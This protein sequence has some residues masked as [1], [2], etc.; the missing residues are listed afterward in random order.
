MITRPMLA[1]TCS[2][3]STL[4]YPVL[5]TPKIDGIRCLTISGQAVSRTFKLIR[6]K[7][8]QH[9][10]R[11]LGYDNLDG[12]IIVPG[13]GFQETTSAVM[14]I[15]GVPNFE[16]N[17]FDYVK[18]HTDKPYRDRINDLINLKGLSVCPWVVRI[19]PATISSQEDL[20]AYEQLSIGNGF[21]G[22]MI[23]S[24]GGPYKCGR[25]TEREGYLLKLKR[26]ED[27]EARIIDIYE[28][29][30][31]A[32][33][34]AYDAFGNIKRAT[35]QEDL[36]P[37]DTMGALEVEDLVTKARFKVGSGFNE[38]LRQHIWD[39]KQEYLGV[40]ITYKYQKHGML[41]VPRLPIFKGFRNVALD[42]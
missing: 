26:F 22:V 2:D 11:S 15:D 35:C 5:C 24:P 6:N 20:N 32:N 19:L 34:V 29:F 39:H 41:D 17:V 7:H 36:I 13:A 14:S 42:L 40:V 1:G 37:L 28:K 27:S 12:E 21:E 38:E 25:S 9:K 23:R 30:Q 31:N 3:V 10:I 33:P 4:N 18:D 8:I 16:Y